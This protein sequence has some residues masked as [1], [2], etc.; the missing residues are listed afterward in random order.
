[1]RSLCRGALQREELRGTLLGG[2]ELRFIGR[3]KPR[4]LQKG[5]EG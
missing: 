2:V 1:M 5:G 4:D 3:R